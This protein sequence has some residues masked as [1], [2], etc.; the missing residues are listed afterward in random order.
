MKITSFEKPTL[1]IIN[2]EIESALQSVATKYGIKISVGN[3]SYNVAE[4]N[5]KVNM[6]VPGVANPHA[7]ILG[8]PTNIEGV[9]F[10]MLGTTYEVVR[11]DAN[12]PKFPIIIKKAE[13]N[14]MVRYK[15]TI[16]QFNKYNKK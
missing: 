4:C 10:K 8:L 16:E 1:R 3:A 14:S 9:Q 11:V 5:V 7:E 6:R 12:K 15:L 2:A 13:E